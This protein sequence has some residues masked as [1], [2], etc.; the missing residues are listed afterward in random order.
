MLTDGIREII[1][2][3]RQA[4]QAVLKTVS[5]NDAGSTKS[6]QCGFLLP[7]EGWNYFTVQSPTKGTN[8][9]HSVVIDWPGGITTR[10][11][12]KWYGKETRNEYRL[13][14]FG[15]GFPYRRPELA[16]SLF[17]YVPSSRAAKTARAWVVDDA[18][19]ADDL[20][21]ALG[22]ELRS[23]YALYPES[24]NKVLTGDECVQ[25]RFAELVAKLSAFPSGDE[26]SGAARAALV[27]C[28]H[29]FDNEPA[30]AWI[31]RCLD[32]EYDLFRK[33]EEKLVGPHVYGG[34]K[35]LGDFLSI[36]QSVLN[37]R[38]SRAGRSLENHAG[39]LLKLRGIRFDARPMI[40]GRPDLVIPGKA[41]YDNPDYQLKRLFVVGV[42]T[43]LK[44]RWRQV[45][46]E[47]P[48]VKRRYLLT[49]DTE[50]SIPQM[51]EMRDAGVCLITPSPSEKVAREWKKRPVQTH[52]V[53][54]FLATVK[55][56]LN[57]A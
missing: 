45:L 46:Q 18:E 38:K 27:K 56:A 2:A 25:A 14:G 5:P 28:F 49:L 50:L 21:A 19:D 39:E 35:T 34:F 42:K 44:D 9:D 30:D 36:A 41:A 55:S 31:S 15:R 4:G 57:A 29:A 26:L 48:R 7:K 37:R 33:V 51:T 40:P 11:T 22:L 53:E 8:D 54:Q 3:I 13:T 1:D 16:G 52:T 17:V 6:H 43:S 24:A 10:S 47:A 23:G 12:V 20:L 32:A